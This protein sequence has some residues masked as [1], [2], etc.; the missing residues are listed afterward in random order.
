MPEI[1]I[2]RQAGYV[3]RSGGP[4]YDWD[5]TSI[6][7]DGTIRTL[8]ISSVV[9][10]NAV[11]VRLLVTMVLATAGHV[12]ALYQPLTGTGLSTE[13][14]QPSVIGQAF[15]V[16][17]FYMLWTTQII[18]YLGL[19]GITVPTFKVLGWLL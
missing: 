2:T 16:N 11:G 1:G 13:R 17:I 8:D 3:V 15:S 19:P 4:S 6:I 9:P 14:L 18:R 7:C 12:I 5:N 10:S